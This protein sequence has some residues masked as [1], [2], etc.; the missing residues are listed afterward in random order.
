MSTSPLKMRK[1]RILIFNWRDLAHNSAGGAEV[2][3]QRVAKEWVKMGHQ[4]TLFCS[5]VEGSPEN[6]LV[7]GIRVI[8]RGGKHS[9]YRQAKKYYQ[10]EGVGNFDLVIDEINTR[11]FGTPKWVK[12]TEVIALIHQVCREVWFY[13]T[14]LIIALIGRFVLEPYWLKKYRNVKTITISVSSKESL[15]DYGLKDVR[16]IPIGF[17]SDTCTSPLEKEEN[18]TVIFV[19]RLAGNKRP[20]HAVEAFKKIKKDYPNAKLWVIG[21][22]RLELKIRK[23][24]LQGVEVLGRISNSEKNTRLSKAHV[25]VV[26]SVREGWGMVVTEASVVGTKSIG[27]DVPGLRDSIR[28][29]NGVLTKPRP[30]ELANAIKT[31]F[32]NLNHQNTQRTKTTGVI[33]WDELSRRILLEAKS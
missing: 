27:Y 11:P 4:V 7:D 20:L 1:L 28:S 31:H 12:D 13:E 18:P 19:G 2:Y 33:A 6:E 3:T 10:N 23:M 29:A 9:V 17:D 30:K 21:T 8:R 14:P 26:T 16:Y 25:I 22:G 5:Y 24:N 32:E 15:E